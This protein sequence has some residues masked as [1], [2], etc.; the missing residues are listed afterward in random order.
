LRATEQQHAEIKKAVESADV[1]KTEHA[2]YD[3]ILH[4]AVTTF[5][6]H[7]EEEE[8]DDLPKLSKMLSPEEN[9]VSRGRLLVCVAYV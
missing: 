7:A 4:K 9:E 6:S 2:D 5:L 1:T 3:Q 8:R